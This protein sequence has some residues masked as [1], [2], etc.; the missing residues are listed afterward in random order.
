MA[1][2]TFPFPNITPIVSVKLDESNYLNWTTQFTLVLRSHDL[3]GIVN[4]SELCPPKFA[5]DSEGKTTSDITTNYM[6]LNQGAKSCTDYL[7]SAKNWSNQLVAVGKPVDDEDLISYVVGGKGPTTSN[8]TFFSH[9]KPPC[10]IC[11]K[12]NHQALDYYHRMDFSYQERHPHAQ[13]AAMAAHTNVTQKED[14]PWFL[15]SGDNT[16]VTSTLNNL[17]LT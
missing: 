13:L 11:G 3:L 7:L 10:Q 6:T 16:Y 12:T 15:D 1:F 4:G 8:N 14:Q 9:S 17:T 2:V 5:T